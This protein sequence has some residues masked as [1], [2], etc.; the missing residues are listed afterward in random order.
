MEMLYPLGDQ[1][2]FTSRTENTHMYIKMNEVTENNITL[3]R[4]GVSD[5]GCN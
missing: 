3:S 2:Y 1:Y 5:V 4:A